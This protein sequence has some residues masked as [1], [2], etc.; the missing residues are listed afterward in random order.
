MIHARALQAMLHLRTA[1]RSP[2]ADDAAADADATQLNREI[3]AAVE[4]AAAG[5]HHGHAAA[6]TPP[7]AAARTASGGAAAIPATGSDATPPARTASGRTY[8][9]PSNSRMN[10][11][12][13]V[14]HIS[15]NLGYREEYRNRGTANRLRKENEALEQVSCGRGR[16]GD[17]A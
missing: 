3:T 6:S 1:P 9:L 12:E 13:F 8:R 10:G 2:A 14:A 7:P 11:P 5:A 17:C 16:G 15:T 4:A